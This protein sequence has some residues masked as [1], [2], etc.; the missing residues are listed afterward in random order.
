MDQTINEG[1]LSNK[2]CPEGMSVEEWQARLRRESAIETNFKIDH[3]D[4]NRIWGDYLVSSNTG[5][6][7]VAFRGVRS[8]KNYCSCLD[9]R[10]NGLG[11]CKHI[12]AVSHYL[13]QNVE[14]Y[15]WAKMEYKAPYT[16]I[17][18]SYKG[19]RSI[20]MRI[21]ELQRNEFV[22]L[23]D[24]YF[25]GEY[26]LPIDR[27]K[28]LNEICRKATAIDDTFR[29][30]EDVFE[31]AKE[32]LDQQ[33]WEAQVEENFPQHRI[34]TPYTSQLPAYIQSKV[35]DYCK[36]GYGLIVNIT[37][38]IITHEIMALAEAICFLEQSRQPLGII[39][40]DSV[41]RMNYWRAV[42][43]QADLGNLP[44]QVVIDHQFAKQVSNTS[45]TCTFVYVDKA[46]SL[47]E[48]RNPVSAALKRLKMEHLFM[49]ITNISQL[50]PVQLSSILQHI[51]PYVLGPFYKFI[52]KY[53]PIFPLRNDGKNLPEIL[54]P[55][56]F[57]HD[58][59]DV[60]KITKELVLMKP[61]TLTP[62][63]EVNNK[64]VSDFIAALEHVLSDESAREKLLELIKRLI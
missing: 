46:D 8:D 13:S 4:N 45:P 34:T 31:L 27:Y 54:K 5:K 22:K 20:K 50:T 41:T 33:D 48:W 17:Y 7:K 21:G 62:G 14:G 24:T 2:V 6:Y 15:P 11:T 19:G 1:R 25:D 61:E 26:T 42:L 56:V 37:D 23:R 30:Y 63:I 36:I 52:H 55:F 53:R 32:V 57:Y 44:I 16:S 43:D 3:L 47:K 58:K 12:E 49:R 35:Y 38:T 59:D 64:A 18:V 9:F 40:V 51:S 39:L 60:T 10:T 29:C 28:D